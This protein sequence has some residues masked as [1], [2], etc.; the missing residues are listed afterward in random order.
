[1]RDMTKAELARKLALVMAENQRLRH[2]L[3]KNSGLRGFF[4]RLARRVA[5][6]S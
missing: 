5:C 3:R 6:N 2:E 1:M 4:G